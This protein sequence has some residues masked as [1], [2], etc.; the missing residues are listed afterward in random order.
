MDERVRA[1]LAEDEAIKADLQKQTDADRL[2][3]ASL[4]A[5]QAATASERLELAQ[6]VLAWAAAFAGS[7]GYAKLAAP[8][9]G[10]APTKTSA[11]VF[12][13]PVPATALNPASPGG[14]VVRL[15]KDGALLVSAAQSPLAPQTA[16]LIAAAAPAVRCAAAADLA[17]AC[18]NAP[19]LRALAAAIDSGEIF[20]HVANPPVL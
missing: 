13:S 6:R 9:P 10:E 11:V 7:D 17:A 20:D 14:T 2:I 15:E 4:Q 5:Q 1:R 18:P 12:T 3:I 16:L 19:L 8:W